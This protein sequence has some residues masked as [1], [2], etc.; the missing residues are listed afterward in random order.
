MGQKNELIMTMAESIML[1][2]ALALKLA[3][4]NHRLQASLDETDAAFENL[5]EQVD[6]LDKAATRFVDEFDDNGDLIADH[7]E[8]L[9][10]HNTFI[11]DLGGRLEAVE[12]LAAAAKRKAR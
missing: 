10:V 8:R 4:D 12:A 7:E 5:A 11:T 3:D 1:L 2:Q 9:T 6:H